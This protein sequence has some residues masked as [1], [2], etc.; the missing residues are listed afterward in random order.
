MILT[1]IFMDEEIKIQSGK[2]KLLKTTPLV[3][4]KTH[5]YSKTISPQLLCYGSILCEMCE[6]Q[7]RTG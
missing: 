4:S 6:K 3:N 2:V 7:S 5:K 1:L